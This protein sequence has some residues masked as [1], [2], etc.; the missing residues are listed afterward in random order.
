MLRKLLVRCLL[1]F[2][3]FYLVTNPLSAAEVVKHAVHVLNA[4]ADNLTGF[5]TRL[6]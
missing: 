4:A 5:L 6:N 3:V 1:L 2:A